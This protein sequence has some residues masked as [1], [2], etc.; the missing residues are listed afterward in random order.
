[1]LADFGNEKVL[2]SMNINI[3]GKGRGEEATKK[4]SGIDRKS[5]VNPG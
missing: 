2:L 3:F 4:K 5:S 1:V